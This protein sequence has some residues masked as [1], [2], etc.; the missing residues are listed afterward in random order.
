MGVTLQNWTMMM[1]KNGRH[2]L[3]ERKYGVL[4][5]GLQFFSEHGPA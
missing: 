2:V 1:T 5:R 4:G 3:E